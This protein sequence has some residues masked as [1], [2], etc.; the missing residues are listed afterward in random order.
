M[1]SEH[2][3]PSSSLPQD[4]VIPHL[5]FLTTS[6]LA[7]EFGLTRLI[8]KRP[9]FS[10][11]KRFGSSLVFLTGNSYL[12]LEGSRRE[13]VIKGSNELMRVRRLGEELV[14]EAKIGY[15]WPLTWKG[16]YGE[17]F[18]VN[19]DRQNSDLGIAERISLFTSRI[20]GSEGSRG[21]FEHLLKPEFD[22][23]HLSKHDFDRAVTYLANRADDHSLFKTNQYLIAFIFGGATLRY[24]SRSGS[25]SPWFRFISKPT[26]LWL[27]PTV[28]FLSQYHEANTLS[29]FEDREA[30]VR[31]LESISGEA[32]K[33]EE[34]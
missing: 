23:G 29:S 1:S 34:T 28:T 12:F 20:W 27:V 19:A 5:A 13:E 26:F 14:K 21:K 9:N 17:E 7:L 15:R 4:L 10:L 6:L 22:A 16:T 3:Q 24:L 32:A 25:T 8:L 31:A 11:T 33:E 18:A 30:V 2:K